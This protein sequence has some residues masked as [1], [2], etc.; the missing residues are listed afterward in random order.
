M[1]RSI[2][3]LCALLALAWTSCGDS[4]RW[5]QAEIGYACVPDLVAPDRTL[6][7]EVR[8]ACGTYCAKVP[9]CTATVQD[10]Q[11]R[12]TLSEDSC[13]DI[14][15]NTCAPQSCM[16]RVV[17]CELPHLAVGDYPLVIPGSADRLLRVREG[18][19]VACRIANPNP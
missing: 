15:P 16:Q 7:L 11:V 10:G 12:L 5:V 19:Q 6:A 18:G 3:F 1:P 14:S 2:L 8:E 9:E 13:G 17:T 4:C